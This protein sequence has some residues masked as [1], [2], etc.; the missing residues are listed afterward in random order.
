MPSVEIRS[1]SAKELRT[2]LRLTLGSRGQSEADLEGQVS[3]FI[4]YARELSLDLGGQWLVLVDGRIVTACTCIESPGRTAVLFLPGAE[5]AKTGRQPLV[6]L[7]SHV[8]EHEAR[9]DMSL[10]QCLIEPDDLHNHLVLQ[11]AGFTDLTTLLYLEWLANERAAPAMPNI[12]PA[13]AGRAIEWVAYD[14][15]RH[16]AFSDLIASTYQD[17]LDCR[18]LS[19]LRRIEDIVSGHK[20]AGR[21]DPHRWLLLRCEGEAAGCI[22][23]GENP[24]RAAL[25]LVYMGVHP[26]FRHRSVGRYLVQQGLFLAYSEGFAVVTLAVDTE[27]LPARVMYESVGFHQTHSRLAMIR[28]LNSTREEA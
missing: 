15:R 1:A 13:L 28:P 17:S 19:G 5:M 9:R 27:N 20:S 4:R 16:Q 8:A 2:V 14:A 3:G 7:I 24:I 18:G 23:F 21:F 25:E 11:E 22:L 6:D 12:P 10:L 26:R